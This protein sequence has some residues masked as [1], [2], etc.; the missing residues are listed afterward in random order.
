MAFY[1]LYTSALQWAGSICSYFSRCACTMGRTSGTK[2]GYPSFQ[3]PWAKSPDVFPGS[4]HAYLRSLFQKEVRLLGVVPAV[5]S[6][7]WIASDMT[8]GYLAMVL[9]HLCASWLVPI[10]CCY[11]ASSASR[12]VLREEYFLSPGVVMWS[13][14]CFEKSLLI[15]SML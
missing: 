4:T 8:W 13:W 3:L 2:S 15:W 1:N 9:V 10:S 14:S 5:S 12:S 11:Q 6:G 7:T